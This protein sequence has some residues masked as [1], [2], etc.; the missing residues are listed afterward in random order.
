MAGDERGVLARAGL[1]VDVRETCGLAAAGIDHHE[2]HPALDRPVQ[3]LA[4]GSRRGTA[5]R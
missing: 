3:L 2:L 4:P 1:E 5:S